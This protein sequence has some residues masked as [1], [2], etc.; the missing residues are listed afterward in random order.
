MSMFRKYIYFRNMH[1]F[2]LFHALSVEL[3]S[4]F[5]MMKC[6]VVMTAR[7]TSLV[8]PTRVIHLPRLVYL[9]SLATALLDKYLLSTLTSEAFSRLLI[10]LNMTEQRNNVK[11]N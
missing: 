5:W 2:F 10:S 7:M 1:F 8:P 9:L 4:C 3:H 11:M 6:I